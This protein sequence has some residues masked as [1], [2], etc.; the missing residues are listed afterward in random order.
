MTAA[1][2]PPFRLVL[3]LVLA[4]AIGPFALQVFL[5]A[6]PAI[7]AGFG[8]SAA[9]AQLVFSLSA[10]AI[11][12]S[13]LF[14]GPISDRVGRRPALIGGL[15][16]YLIGSVICAVA[17]T[18]TV[19]IVGR[20]VQAA[21]GCA[22]IVLTRAI[23][24]DLYGLERSASLL[25]YITMAM[26][27][28]PMVAPAVGGLLSDAAGWRSVFVAGALLGA[29]VMLAVHRG[30]PETAPPAPATAPRNPFRGF[31]PLLRSPAFLGYV[32]QGAWSIAVFYA[33][34]AAAPFVMTTVLHRPAAEYGLMFMLVPGAFMVG[35]FLAGRY[36]ARLGA[37][38]MILL[39]SLGSFAGALATLLW[40]LAAP[41][42]AWA[43]FLPTGFGALAQGLAMPNAQAAFVSLY[44]D[45][46]GTA[47]S[48]GGFLQMGL[49]AVVAQIVGSI[50]DG[51]PYPMA[52]GMSLC[53]AAALISA[54]VAVRQRR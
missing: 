40:L 3:V 15:V 13:T 33:F 7:Q 12:V 46:A 53:A 32:L 44:P 22:G 10:F 43:I 6:L 52:V 49:A 47:S 19:L 28:A 51:T 42:S 29:A 26:V 30:L 37:E 21:G 24:R 50:Q 48:L 11:A 34:L 25:A 14:Y 35:N 2:A 45:A 39:G 23:V 1:E 41:W 20:I 36:T 17:P 4:T 5:P 16:L 9:T 31:A 54:L 18:V 38:R 8:V 27:A